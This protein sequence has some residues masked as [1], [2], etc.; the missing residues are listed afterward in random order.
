M[1]AVI[2]ADGRPD[3]NGLIWWKEHPKNLAS[4]LPTINKVIASYGLEPI[5]QVE[6]LNIGDLTLVI[7]TREVDPI[8][9]GTQCTHIGPV[10]WEKTDDILPEWIENM[11]H[12]PLIWVYPGNPR[13]GPKETF[14]DSAIIIRACIQVLSKIDANVILTTGNHKLPKELLPLPNNFHFAA[15]LPGLRLAQKCD[16][17][18]HHGGYGSCQTGLYT[19]TP[20]VIVPTF[21]E[22][23]S[24][25]RRV[26]AVGAGE[27]VFPKANGSGKRE[28]DLEEFQEK[29]NR[30]LS[31]PL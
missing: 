28:I 16:L 5:A 25:A 24:N 31:T 15:Y 7:G 19:G 22:R 1:I 23:E 6:E 29:I 30:V 20:A 17:M 27:C 18:I 9:E 4:A 11:D 21:S 10:L 26:A 3:N 14:L 13:Y 8:P 12:K 2:Q